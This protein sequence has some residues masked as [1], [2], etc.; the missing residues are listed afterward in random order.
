MEIGEELIRVVRELAEANEALIQVAAAGDSVHAA[1]LLNRVAALERRRNSLVHSRTQSPTGRIAGGRYV[2]S[3]PLRDL[4]IRVLHLVTRPATGPLLADVTKAR[5]GERL[6]TTAFSSLRR[7]EFRSWA[8]GNDT[9]R[10]T[11][12][13]DVYVVPALSY[14]RFAP[15]RGTLALSTWETARRLIAPLSPRVDMLKSTIALAHEADRLSDTSQ[16]EALMRLVGRLGASIPGARPF[17]AAPT[18]V[19]AAAKAELNELEEIDKQERAAA[20]E[21][22]SAQLD[23]ETLLFGGPLRTSSHSVVSGAL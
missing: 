8:A 12:I 19:I 3:A 10:R 9:N 2:S 1:E 13:R 4:V 6:E 7:D 21:R 22:A 20:A 16:G 17:G 23:P 18:E 14:D 5:W 11:A 15:V